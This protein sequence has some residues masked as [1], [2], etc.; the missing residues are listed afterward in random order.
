M[1]SDLSHTSASSLPADYMTSSE[2][3]AAIFHSSRS[4][5][6]GTTRFQGA[7]ELEIFKTSRY[8]R[9]WLLQPQSPLKHRKSNRRGSLLSSLL[10][11]KNKAHSLILTD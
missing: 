6:L 11:C 2:H 3:G 9:P 7:T 5:Y 1:D 10:N 4:L 8:S